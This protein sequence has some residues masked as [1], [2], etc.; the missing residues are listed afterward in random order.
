MTSS[1]N[2]ERARDMLQAHATHRKGWVDDFYHPDCAWT[3]LPIHGVNE[4]RRGG[5]AEL[6]KASDV[7]EKTF[8]ALTIEPISLIGEDDRVAIEL[9]FTG[10]TKTHEG[11]DKPSRVSKLRMAIFLTFKD[12]KIISQTDYLVPVG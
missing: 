1:K 8:E 2:V 3:E 12:G 11:S 7:A 6:Q 10:V 4:G 9:D 5:V